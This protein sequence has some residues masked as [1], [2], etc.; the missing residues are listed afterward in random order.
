MKVGV[1]VCVCLCVNVW[2]C[3]AEWVS[4]LCESVYESKSLCVSGRFWV[5]VCVSVCMDLW[6]SKVS[7]CALHLPSIQ[8]DIGKLDVHMV[9]RYDDV[10]TVVLP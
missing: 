1:C 10:N 7:V 6:T 8:R 9:G 4:V 3:M 2:L 5:C